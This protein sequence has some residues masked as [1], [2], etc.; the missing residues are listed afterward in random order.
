MLFL[1]P[2]ITKRAIKVRNPL[3]N[4]KIYKYVQ[5]QLKIEIRKLQKNKY[6]KL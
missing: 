4:S 5:L 3:N 6:K 2:R 1:M